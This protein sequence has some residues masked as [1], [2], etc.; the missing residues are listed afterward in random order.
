[1]GEN[2]EGGSGGRWAGWHSGGTRAAGGAQCRS[3]NTISMFGSFSRETPPRR[4]IAAAA[5]HTEMP[6][7]APAR[8]TCGPGSVPNRG[9]H[10][11]RSRGTGLHGA[12]VRG[13]SPPGA[14]RRRGRGSTDQ[15]IE[16]KGK[17]VQAATASTPPS[18]DFSSSRRSGR[19]ARRSVLSHSHLLHAQRH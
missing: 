19:H 18:P 1:M 6:D 11:G 8:G 14:R 10:T 3:A 2:D 17:I 15:R 9:V 12:T 4:C 5:R 7:E 16:K 13:V